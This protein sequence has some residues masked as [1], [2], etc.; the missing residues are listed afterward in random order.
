MLF[1]FETGE[2]ERTFLDHAA[3]LPHAPLVSS[4]LPTLAKEGVLGLSWHLPPPHPAD[5]VPLHAVRTVQR[6][7]P[8]SPSACSQRF[9]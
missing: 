5:R 4:N 2:A 1:L 9:L 7:V 6:H 3:V 8:T